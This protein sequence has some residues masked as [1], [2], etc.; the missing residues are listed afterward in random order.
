MLDLLSGREGPRDPDAWIDVQQIHSMMAAPLLG[1]D[2]LIG[3]ITV[4]STA[5]NA[6]DEQD[7]EDL[8]GFPALRSGCGEHFGGGSADVG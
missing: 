5:S 4:Q 7:A 2:R 3:T 1:P 6:F 8:G